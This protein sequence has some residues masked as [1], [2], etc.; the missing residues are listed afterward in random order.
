MDVNQ[1]SIKQWID[2]EIKDQVQDGMNEEAIEMAGLEMNNPGNTEC[3][4][5]EDI[6]GDDVRKDIFTSPIT[7]QITV[8]GMFSDLENI[9]FNCNLLELAA[10]LHRA[11]REVE[12]E[13]AT[14]A[15][16]VTPRQAL[17]TELWGAVK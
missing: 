12:L 10:L 1:V 3:S 16:R 9:S 14:R 17:I 5:S 7:L 13:R 6:D 15:G 11:K 2:I 4:A 8:P